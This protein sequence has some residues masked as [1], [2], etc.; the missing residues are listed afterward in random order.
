MKAGKFVKI[1]LAV[2]MLYGGVVGLRLIKG[3]I[4]TIWP[5]S[6]PVPNVTLHDQSILDPE[7]EASHW[8]LPE[9]EATEIQW[10]NH[11][12]SVPGIVT[13]QKWS[14]SGRTYYQIHGPVNPDYGRNSP[15]YVICRIYLFNDY[16]IERWGVS[17]SDNK[18]VVCQSW[19]DNV[20]KSVP[21]RRVQIVFKEDYL[22]VCFWTPAGQTVGNIVFEYQEEEYCA[23]LATEAPG[24]KDHDN[25]LRWT[26]P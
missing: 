20:A 16:G 10:T 3:M 24:T 19:I 6:K 12:N 17:L 26:M 2:G 18:S 13:L 7:E 14:V 23:Y 15:R 22:T 11:T 4:N 8:D 5:V 1:L 9:T 21:E 25:V